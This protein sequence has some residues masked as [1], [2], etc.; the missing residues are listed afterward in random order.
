MSPPPASA[1]PG[2]TRSASASATS[3]RAPS[4]SAPAASPQ[5]RSRPPARLH[6][7]LASAI[8]T[9]AVSAE[10]DSLDAAEQE[11]LPPAP[12]KGWLEW[13]KFA[14]RWTIAIVGVTWVVANLTIR[15]R[16][17]VLA[18]DAQGRQVLLDAPVAEPVKL[19]RNGLVLYE[20]PRT[21]ENA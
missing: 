4:S 12:R 3:P 21:G 15:D 20:D 14:L 18:Q 11:D 1:W 8:L 6:P 19:A 7:S 10:S 13:L 2:S 16:V 9:H 17:H 5:N